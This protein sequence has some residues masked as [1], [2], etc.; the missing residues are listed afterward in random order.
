MLTQER[1]FNQP[2][3]KTAAFII[4][5]ASFL[6]MAIMTIVWPLIWEYNGIGDMGILHDAAEM[7]IHGENSYLVEVGG[8]SFAYPPNAALPL[9]LFSLIPRSWVMYVFLL[10]NLA[11]LWGIIHMGMKSFIPDFS[12]KRLDLN[13]GLAVALLVFTPANVGL[14]QLS[15]TSIVALFFAF[16][17]WHYHRR[18]IWLP[19][20]IFL[21][22]GAMKPQ[23]IL[24]PALWILLSRDFKTI[25]GAVVTGVL[26]MVPLFFHQGPLDIVRD[27]FHAMS[28]YGGYVFNTPGHQDVIGLQSFLA[29]F[30]I[31]TITLAPLV[32]VAFVLL[33][34]FKGRIA[35]AWHFPL[36][37]AITFTFLSAHEYDFIAMTPLWLGILAWGRKSWKHWVL[38]WFTY[39]VFY[40]P[41][42]IFRWIING[43]KA[44]IHPL[45]HWRV[46]VVMV[47]VAL[48]VFWNFKKSEER[49]L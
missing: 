10:M 45:L 18:G 7:W 38:S 12:W 35:D 36:L 34:I 9:I 20:G 28:G 8:G 6:G 16:A 1:V 25:L 2:W 3:A 47:A 24:L 44:S 33:F 30:G 27:W 40:L 39:G 46:I 17:A 13:Q 29:S 22:L 42:R 23:Y 32:L 31:P 11:A 48:V 14:F 4:V 21:A 49:P 15:Q 37:M 41:V 19:S 5:I 43:D 26:F